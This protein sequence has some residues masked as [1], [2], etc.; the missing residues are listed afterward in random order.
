MMSLSAA[1][2]GILTGRPG[3]AFGPTLHELV[4]VFTLQR[5]GRQHATGT[6]WCGADLWIAVLPSRGLSLCGASVWYR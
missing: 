6:V 1:C 4:M 5:G 3:V 2:L